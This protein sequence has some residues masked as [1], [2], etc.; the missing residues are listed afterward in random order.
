MTALIPD[1]LFR[2]QSVQTVSDLVLSLL[3]LAAIIE[4]C[5][6]EAEGRRV[7]RQQRCH[8]PPIIIG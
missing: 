2:W 6:S 3:Q 1:L 5:S 4:F 8:T 7:Q